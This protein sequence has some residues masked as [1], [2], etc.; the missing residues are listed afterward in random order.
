MDSA[1]GARGLHVLCEK[2]MAVTARDCERVIRAT[3]AAN[4]KLVS[5]YRLH[6]EQANLQAGQLA[7]S[8]KLGALR[9]FSS[10]FSMQVRRRTFG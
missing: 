5:A 3:E 10:G 6:F 4:V 8:G 1:G 2:P 9:F 7:R